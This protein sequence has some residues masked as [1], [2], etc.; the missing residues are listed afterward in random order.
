MLRAGIVQAYIAL[1]FFVIGVINLPPYNLPLPLQPMWPGL[2]IF[3]SGAV[4][5]T[6][7]HPLSR[8]LLRGAQGLMIVLGTSRALAVLL[9][10]NGRESSMVGAMLWGL[11]VVL[12]FTFDR[13]VLTY[14]AEK[15]YIEPLP[16]LQQ[17]RE[18][19]PK[20]RA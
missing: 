6:I 17:S 20:D 13:I 14:A 5:G 16:E 10:G 7:I 8:P 1:A 9:A 18:G 11:I 2:F 3:C 12:G 15:S 19:N 4:I